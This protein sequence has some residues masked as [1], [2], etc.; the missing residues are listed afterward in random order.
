MK[1]SA[2][3]RETAEKPFSRAKWQSKTSRGMRARSSCGGRFRNG[4]VG[5]ETF[6]S[7]AITGQKL[8]TKIAD[9]AQAQSG[10]S[11]NFLRHLLK[12]ILDHVNAVGAGD[13]L[14]QIAQN[15]PVVPRFAGRADGAI[16]PLQATVDVDERA[17]FFGE[18]A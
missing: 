16:E 5:V 10:E 4:L 11:G 3:P 15:F 13:G 14:D 12:H 18:A 17:A 8:H 1:P 2:T 6:R 9:F 7:F